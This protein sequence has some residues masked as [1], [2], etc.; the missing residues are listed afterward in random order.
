MSFEDEYVEKKHN[1]KGTSIAGFLPVLGL[2]M[3]VAIGA[4]A[5]VLSGPV[6]ELLMENLDNV[7]ADQEVQ[8]VV[9]GVLFLVMLLFA[10]MIFA[11]FAPKPAKTVSEMELKKEKMGKE[12]D[13][14]AAKRRKQQMA[15]QMAAE[16][17]KRERRG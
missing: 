5:F 1:Q 17:A 6:H 15:R 8:Y 10:A 7:P 13:R 16:R 3:A 2:V 14:K 11:A 4:V 9:G 12:R